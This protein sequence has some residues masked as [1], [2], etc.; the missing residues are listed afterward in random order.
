MTIEL[1]YH[2]P[3]SANGGESPFD[4]KIVSISRNADV[5]IVCPYISTKLL[6]RIGSICNSWQLLSDIEAW[7]S[8]CTYSEKEE[9]YQFVI[10]NLGS[11]RH[12]SKL[13]AKLVLSNN[14]ALTGSANLTNSGMLRNRELA[15]FVKEENLVHELWQWFN[16]LWEEAYIPEKEK[17]TLAFQNLSPRASEKS[18]RTYL[19]SPI[20]EINSTLAM[21]ENERFSFSRTRTFRF[22]DVFPIIARIIQEYSRT[23]GE[24]IT[25]AELTIQLSKDN[26]A[27]KYIDDAHRIRKRNEDM[28]QTDVL[29][30]SNMIAHFS[31]QYTE[32]INKWGDGLERERI[33]NKWAY[34]MKTVDRG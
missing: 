3:H 7:F 1:I 28:P 15:V 27:R 29:I 25:H 11:I 31:R 12:I 8:S 17:V 20:K 6:K 9:T 10:S 26:D 33:K 24:F 18:S 4:A 32:G 2:T 21:I 34:R 30:A 5:A 14:G 19:D 23:S 16:N 22:V 13:H